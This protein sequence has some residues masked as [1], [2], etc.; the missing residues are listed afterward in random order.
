M[1]VALWL[2]FAFALGCW[3]CQ[4]V[5]TELG[6]PDHGGMVWDEMVAVWLVLWLS[7]GSWAGQL[8]AFGLFRVFDI[9]KPAPI[10]FF[11]RRLPNGFGVM[12]DDLLAAG[13]SLLVMLVLVQ[14][15]VVS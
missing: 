3:V 7:P 1:A 10:R 11:D 2:V 8:L 9:V 15:G 12:W 6:Q 14:L 5:G 13:Y 4:R